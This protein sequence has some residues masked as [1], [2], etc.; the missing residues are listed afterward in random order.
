MWPRGGTDGALKISC[1]AVY[2]GERR[3]SGVSRG[4]LMVLSGGLRRSTAAFG[5]F[6]RFPVDH[7]LRTGAGPN[8]C[9]LATLGDFGDFSRK[10]PRFPFGNLGGGWQS[11]AACEGGIRGAWL[12]QAAYHRFRDMQAKSERTRERG[13]I[14]FSVERIPPASGRLRPDFVGLEQ[15]GSEIFSSDDDVLDVPVL[16]MSN[17]ICR[18][19]THRRLTAIEVCQTRIASAPKAQGNAEV[20]VGLAAGVF[21]SDRRGPR[22]ER[23]DGVRLL[24]QEVDAMLR[25]GLDNLGSDHRRRRGHAARHEL[26]P[27]AHPRRFFL[28]QPLTQ[29]IWA[30]EA[31]KLLHHMR[32]VM[33]KMAREASYAGRQL[34]RW[35]G[36]RAKPNEYDRSDMTNCRVCLCPRDF[37]SLSSVTGPSLIRAQPDRLHLERRDQGMF[38]DAHQFLYRWVCVHRWS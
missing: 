15:R 31:M 1:V 7:S 3:P 10:L 29:P 35:C 2:G 5:S 36:N 19:G 9:V 28:Y 34:R 6:S 23:H 26:V 33:K 12:E 21:T 4:F 18:V 17:G 14:P 27:E 25:E 13:P 11:R 32:W 24:R 37:N 38:D 20:K 16:Q 22:V 30:Y 8:F